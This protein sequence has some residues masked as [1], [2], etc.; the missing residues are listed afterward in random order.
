LEPRV[1]K[2]LQRYKTKEASIDEIS[3]DEVG[4]KQRELSTLYFNYFEKIN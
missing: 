1:L 4:E 3:L 2:K